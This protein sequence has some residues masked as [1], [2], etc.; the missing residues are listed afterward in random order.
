MEP[1]KKKQY[2]SVKYTK[3]YIDAKE[4]EKII[5]KDTVDFVKRNF[6]PKVVLDCGCGYGRSLDTFKIKAHKIIGIDIS[7]KALAKTKNYIKDKVFFINGDVEN[8][9]FKDKSV[10]LILSIEVISYTD[11]F[12]KALI[13]MKRVLADNGAIVISVENKYGGI[14]CDPYLEKSELKKAIKY[15]K[16]RKTKYF[17]EE[18]ITNILEELGFRIVFRDKIGFTYS[19]IFHRFMFS[20]CEIRNI[21]SICKKDNILSELSRGLCFV[22]VKN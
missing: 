6:F 20:K 9:P 19:G 7:K 8:L 5:Y 1:N 3:Q 21:E 4:K 22:C 10:D 14:L 18:E 11:N 12:K 13:E 16:T 15:A 17:T 2:D